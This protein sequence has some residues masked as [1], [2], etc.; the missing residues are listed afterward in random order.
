MAKLISRSSGRARAGKAPPDGRLGAEGVRVAASV[1]SK[2]PRPSN[3]RAV[4]FVDNFLLRTEI[5]VTLFS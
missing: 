4:F 5:R 2:E 3:F 1:D